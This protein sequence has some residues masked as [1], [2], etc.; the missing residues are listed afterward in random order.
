MGSTT[1][2]VVCIQNCQYLTGIQGAYWYRILELFYHTAVC[3]SSAVFTKQSSTDGASKMFSKHEQGP[4][5]SCIKQMQRCQYWIYAQHGGDLDGELPNNVDSKVIS[6]QSS[7]NGWRVQRITAGDGISCCSLVTSYTA[8]LCK[9]VIDTNTSRR[10]WNRAKFFNI[11]HKCTCRIT[12]GLQY[13]KLLFCSSKSALRKMK[14]QTKHWKTMIC[15]LPIA[16]CFKT[17]WMKT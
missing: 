4:V 13:K 10:I 8:I 5:F 1:W 14:N 3:S 11:F 12:C 9:N 15:T 17:H 16:S 7:K 6:G 2:R